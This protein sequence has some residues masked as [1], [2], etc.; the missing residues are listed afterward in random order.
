MKIKNRLVRKMLH[1]SLRIIGF[2]CLFLGFFG[3]LLPIMPGWLLIIVGILII[4]E[5]SFVTGWLINKLPPKPRKIV[6]D[7]LQKIKDRKK[8]DEGK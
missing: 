1:K 8:E 7:R 5:E 2:L 4:G 6:K 3:L